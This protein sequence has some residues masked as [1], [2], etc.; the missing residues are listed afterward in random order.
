M[1]RSAKCWARL[2]LAWWSRLRRRAQSGNTALCRRERKVAAG[3][4]WEPQ[5]KR[6]MDSKIVYNPHG[7]KSKRTDHSPIWDAAWER[8][9]EESEISCNC[10]TELYIVFQLLPRSNEKLDWEIIRSV[11]YFE[12]QLS[13]G[14]QLWN[15]TFLLLLF[16]FP[17]FEIGWNDLRP[18]RELLKRA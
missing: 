8:S 2:I 17:S 6:R 11:R 4:H 10:T 15:E 18:K 7:T 16:Q 13:L 5:M 1:L 14:H 3:L 12:K 9:S